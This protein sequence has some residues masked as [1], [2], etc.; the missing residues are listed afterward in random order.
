MPR[1]G[2]DWFIFIVRLA[3]GGFFVWASVDKIMHPEAFAKII[4]NYRILPPEYINLLAIV[5]PWI[6]IVAGVCLMVGYKYRGANLLILGMLVVFIVALAASYARGLNINC[7][8]FST[9]TSVKSNLL[10]RIVEDIL[11]AAGCVLVFLKS[12]LFKLSPA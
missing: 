9:A 11:M 1:T 7:G 6:E 10:W 4:H 5:L 3:V 12:K 8:C 2:G